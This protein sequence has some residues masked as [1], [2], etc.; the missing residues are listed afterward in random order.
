MII[1]G[2]GTE[3]GLCLEQKLF[4]FVTF[5]NDFCK[6]GVR[7]EK[8]PITAILCAFFEKFGIYSTGNRESF[9]VFKIGTGEISPK[10]GEKVTVVSRTDFF[11]GVTAA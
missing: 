9:A 10:K 1:Q 7:E 3:R 11:L 8:R 5:V 4:T 6:G 2:S